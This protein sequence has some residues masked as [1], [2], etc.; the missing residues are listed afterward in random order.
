[1]KLLSLIPMLVAATHLYSCP[2]EFTNDGKTGIYI[3]Q[4]ENDVKSGHFI[5]PGQKKLIPGFVARDYFL[6]FVQQKPEGFVEE[7]RVE[8]DACGEEG[9]APASIFYSQ[10]RKALATPDHKITFPHT[11]QSF[12][13]QRGSGQ[14]RNFVV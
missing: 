4:D 3:V 14:R 1:M 12:F 9:K 6:V 7:F 8:E 2:F 10:L 11:E 5:A 13:V